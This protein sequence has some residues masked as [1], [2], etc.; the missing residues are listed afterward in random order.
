MEQKPT[1]EQQRQNA[2][3]VPVQPF[4]TQAPTPAASVPPPRPEPRPEI[5]RQAKPVER[6]APEQTLAAAGLSQDR[7]GWRYDE[8]FG[9]EKIEDATARK[10]RDEKPVPPRAAQTPQAPK[11]PEK[12]KA[13]QPQQWGYGT[14]Y[15]QTPEG[16]VPIV[17][18]QHINAGHAAAEQAAASAREEQQRQKDLAELARAARADDAKLRTSTVN[19]SGLFESKVAG[20]IRGDAQ[21]IRA[22]VREERQEQAQTDWR[23]WAQAQNPDRIGPREVAGRTVQAAGQVVRSGYRVVNRATG[24]VSSLANFASHLLS[25]PSAP[26]EQPNRISM[27]TLTTDPEARKQYQL[28]QHA[29]AKRRGMAVEALDNI[30]RDIAAGRDLSAA[31]VSKLP[32]EQLVQIASGGDAYVNQLIESSRKRADEYWK[33]REHTPD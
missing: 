14:S 28:A 5:I 6:P 16:D 20:A 21:K 18:I 26:P 17:P 8:N 9:W 27:R 15:V 30:Q 29:E 2:Q 33:G 1:D 4:P 7:A 22:Q 13:P 32:R 3:P 24:A 31:D 23:H 25:G 12:T 11:E 19:L 10:G